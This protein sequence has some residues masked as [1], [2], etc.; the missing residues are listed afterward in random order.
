MQTMVRT[1]YVDATELLMWTIAVTD[2]PEAC[3]GE[4]FADSTSSLVRNHFCG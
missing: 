1:I 3:N 4:N 2:A